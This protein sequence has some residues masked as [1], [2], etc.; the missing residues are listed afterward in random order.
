MNRQ[1]A[2]LNQF[3]IADLRISILNLFPIADLRISIF[4]FFVIACYL[5]FVL[6]TL[7][8]ISKEENQ[9]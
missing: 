5:L 8:E 9:Q 4:D 3:W 7:F 6:T 1:S 2:I